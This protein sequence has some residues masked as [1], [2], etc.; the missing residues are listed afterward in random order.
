MN[1]HVR[2][3]PT[4][5]VA[6]RIPNERARRYSNCFVQS[7]AAMYIDESWQ[8]WTNFASAPGTLLQ[9]RG[10]S[11]HTIWG[12]SVASCSFQPHPC[13]S[14][15]LSLRSLYL[16]KFSVLI[17]LSCHWMETWLMSAAQKIR[18]SAMVRKR[19]SP[20]VFSRVSSSRSL[21]Q[22]FY[23]IRLA[24]HGSGHDHLC[25]YTGYWSPNG[26]YYFG[27]HTLAINHAFEWP[28]YPNG[29]RV[30]NHHSL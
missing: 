4:R 7:F 8:S 10:S 19:C 16:I 12:F 29:R 15:F 21:K 26:I 13:C 18:V 6:T 17:V 14:Q 5:R 27:C 28:S 20:K 23:S 24:I 25:Y 22:I 1:V 9:N 30:L 3:L 11:F 2:Y